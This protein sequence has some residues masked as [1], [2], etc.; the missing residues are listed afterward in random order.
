MHN[1]VGKP[2]SGLPNFQRVGFLAVLPALLRHLGADAAE[3]LPAAGLDVTALNDP[4]G[5]IPYAAMGRLMAVAVDRTGC[6]H[7]GL[8]LGAQITIASL[9]VLGELMGNVPTL[10]VALQDFAAHQHRNA[11]GGIA[12]LLARDETVLFGYT[13]YQP[14]MAAIPQVYDGAAAAAFNVVCGL[15]EGQA[16]KLQVLLSR[17]EPPDPQPY[18]RLFGAKPRFNAG[19][20][21]VQFSRHW[22]DQP[23]A[24]ACAERRKAVEQ[25]VAAFSPA[26]ALGVLAQVRR[27][28]QV[29]LLSGPPTDAEAGALLGLH[30]RTLHR[31]LADE[32]ATFQTVLNEA[33]CEMAQQLLANTPLSVGD[34]SL[35][36]RYVDPSIFTRAFR[37]W[38]GTTPKAWRA[39]AGAMPMDLGVDCGPTDALGLEEHD[40]V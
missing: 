36:L 18:Q 1:I 10:G 35:L 13:V 24:G 14:C 8:L 32:G 4:E 11:R 30:Q 28:L 2:P 21:G 37:R 20:T 12:Y 40:E 38:T 5:T 9:G 27:A 17:A 19:Q 3:V 22:L 33:R 16:I 39:K 6:P 26:G 34:V 15:V 7:L 31:R 25:R 29:A 23:V